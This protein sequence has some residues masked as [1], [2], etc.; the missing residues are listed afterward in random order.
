MAKRSTGLRFQPS[1]GARAA[2]LPAGKKQRLCIERLAHDGRG[3]AHEG[4]RTWFVAGAL[5]G[6]TV[7]ARV[8]AARN[9]IVE[10]RVERLIATSELRREPPCALAGRCGGCTLQHLAQAEQVALK[11]RSLADQLHRLAALEPREWAAPLL[12][13][14]FGYRRRARL[15]VRYDPK[16]RHLAVGFRAAASQAIVDVDA[17]PVL[18]QALQPL[19]AALPGVLRSLQRPQAIGHVELFHGTA[20]ALLVR[21]TQPLSE[22]DR[23]ALRSLCAEQGA[24]LWW[25]GEGEPQA[26]G[27]AAALGYRLQD[28]ALTLAW[29]PGDF[30]QVNAEVNAAM[31]ARRWTGWRPAQT[32]GCSIC[33]AGWVTSPCRWRGAAPRWSASRACRRWSSGPGPT[34]RPTAWTTCSFTA[35]TCPRRWARRAGR[36]AVSPRCCSIRRATVRRRWWG[37]CAAWGPGAYSMY[38]AIRRPWRAMRRCWRSRAT[39]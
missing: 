31:L 34:P 9:Q 27:E 12:G 28:E 13:S 20:S 7:E 30:V 22:V 8:L 2:T 38:R 15:A 33:S 11:Q 10:A 37:S 4:G 17:C 5:A 6:E 1:G 36:A 23:Q 19:L 18:V 26:D 16:S 32:S 25:Q 14:E 24:Q 21:H 3:I 39:G 29:R 35:P